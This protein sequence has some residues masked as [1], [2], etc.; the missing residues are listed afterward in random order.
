M[1]W[2]KVPEIALFLDNTAAFIHD[3]PA[4][5]LSTARGDNNYVR[6]Q[7][8]TPVGVLDRDKKLGVVKE[9]TELVSAAAH[10][11]DLVNRTWVLI[12]EAPD[13]GWGIDGHAYTGAE[14]GE[15]ARREL[16]GG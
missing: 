7:V 14:I 8:L 11:P 6:V 10:D 12:T 1:R 16:A 13:G 15:A 9:M 5:A 2:E 3:L 4:D